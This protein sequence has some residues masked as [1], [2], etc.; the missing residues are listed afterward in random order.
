M[1]AAWVV[2]SGGLLGSALCRELRR[3]G[4]RLFAPLE[5]FRWDSEAD[6]AVQLDAAVKA[7]AAFA[8]AEKRWQ[9]YWAA[10]VGAMSSTEAELAVE[11]RALSTL[12]NL[13]ASEPGLIVEAGCFA[14]ASSAGAIYAGA[15]D[16]IITENTPAAPTTA[17][18]HEKLRQENLF[19]A[20]ALANCRVA[21]LLAR[22][23]TLYG[24]GQ[25]TGRQQGLLALIARRI[26]RNQPIQIYVPFDTIR[27]Y[28]T[29]DDAALAIIAA[30]RTIDGQS[31][32]FTKIIASEQPTTIA[33]IIS[34]YKRI[35]RRTPRVVTSANNLSSV[36]TRRIQ[37]RSIA[38]MG[39]EPTTRTSLAVG[40]ARV[41]A[42]ERFAFARSRG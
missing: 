30:L 4:I 1:T 9:I 39:N 16:D 11:T 23:S 14:F 31:G 32:A 24:P 15:T 19:S 42:A 37:F 5:C 26:L 10:G 13:V 27:D 7:F 25:T 8:G 38:V 28:M 3:R 22:I 35:A 12:L 41:M 34:I 21:V 2:G 29:A 20:F 40:I 6:L 17:Y 18:A 33:E 36:Y